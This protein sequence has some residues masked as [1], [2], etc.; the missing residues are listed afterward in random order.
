MGGA[1]L[2]RAG[3]L[4]PL[5]LYHLLCRRVLPSEVSAPRPG[6]SRDLTADPPL[7]PFAGDLGRI[8]IIPI[9]GVPSLSVSV[10]VCVCNIYMFKRR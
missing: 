10:S 5:L 6:L 4:P 9:S 7:P 1:P 3:M 8:R 2:A